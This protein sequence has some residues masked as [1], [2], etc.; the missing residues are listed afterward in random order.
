MTLHHF[1]GRAGYVFEAGVSV[2]NDHEKRSPSRKNNA[3][4]ISTGYLEWL[5]RNLGVILKRDILKINVRGGKDDK[6]FNLP[7]YR[8][9]KKPHDN[10]LII[11][12]RFY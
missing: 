5:P 7:Y 1:C 12:I 8:K 10:F 2:I 9:L 11:R 3:G 6:D 4:H